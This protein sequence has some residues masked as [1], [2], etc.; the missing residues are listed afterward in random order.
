MKNKTAKNRIVHN[1]CRRLY[2][3]GNLLLILKIRVSASSLKSML[4][5]SHILCVSRAYMRK[6]SDVAGMAVL[7]KKNLRK[8]CVNLGKM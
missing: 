2:S 7:A 8:K 3:N 6:T 1:L 5:H 4:Q